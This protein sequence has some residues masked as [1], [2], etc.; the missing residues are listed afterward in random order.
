MA[1][2]AIV[3]PQCCH[4]NGF[5]MLNSTALQTQS[6]KAHKKFGAGEDERTSVFSLG[7]IAVAVSLHRIKSVPISKLPLG[8]HFL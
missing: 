6:P 5:K 1:V 7:L 2:V 3:L 8:Y 4:S